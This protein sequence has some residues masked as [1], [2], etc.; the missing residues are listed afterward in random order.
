VP[1]GEVSAWLAAGDRS[2]TAIDIAGPLGRFTLDDSLHPM[3]LVAGGSG[4]SAIVALAE[5][6]ARRRVA[7]DCLLLHGARRRA[8]LF[9]EDL[10][11]EVARA[12]HPAYRFRFEQVL[13]DEPPDSPWPGARG[14]VS[15]YLREELLKCGADARQAV[16]WLCGPPPM[17]AAAV[18]HLQD[19]GVPPQ[20]ILRDLFTDRRLPAPVID[21]RQCALCDECLLVR[22]VADCIV[23]AHTVEH[24]ADGRVLRF[25]RLTPTLTA[26]LYYHSLVIDPER[27]LRC[28]A[29]VHACPHGAIRF[30][31]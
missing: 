1:G 20:H 6:A 10:I 8:D 19:L 27:C 25:E 13:S 17:I 18:A 4:L 30:A 31:G 24:D 2:G 15:D 21:N 29:C 23:E 7:R 26:G 14:L 28:L 3:L 11:S 22:P 12:W 5:E 16:V 9:A